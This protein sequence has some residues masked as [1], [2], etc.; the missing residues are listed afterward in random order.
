MRD[1]LGRK[2]TSPDDERKDQQNDSGNGKLRAS[3]QSTMNHGSTVQDAPTQNSN[4]TEGRETLRKGVESDLSPEN[5]LFP[6][7]QPAVANGNSGEILACSTEKMINLV[8]TE[9]ILAG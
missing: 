3:A 7:H 1:G 5:H 6:L 2:S 4:N 8:P 9:T